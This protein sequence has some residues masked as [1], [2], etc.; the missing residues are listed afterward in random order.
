MLNRIKNILRSRKG[1][2]LVEYGILVGGVALVCLAAVAIFGHKTNDLI[3]VTAATLPA[4]HE[5]DAGAIVSGQLV[6]TEASPSGA[7][8]LA[9]TP[10]SMEANLGLG[11]L[12]S[13]VVEAGDANTAP[14]P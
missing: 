12:D 10:G 9:A 6:A 13:L 1:Q 14:T 7:L 2:S 4:A 11:E 5:E 8:R 3:A